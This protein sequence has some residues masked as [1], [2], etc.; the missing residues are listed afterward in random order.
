MSPA[1]LTR[2]SDKCSKVRFLNDILIGYRS[3]VT[4]ADKQRRHPICKGTLTVIPTI[5]R[6]SRSLRIFIC[7]VSFNIPLVENSKVEE[8][9]P[10]NLKK[11]PNYYKQSK[12]I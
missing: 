11:G 7:F 9:T 2:A 6:S 12:H 1:E 5:T 8:K 4:V 10:F 3:A